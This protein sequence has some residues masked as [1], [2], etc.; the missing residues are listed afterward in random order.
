MLQFYTCIWCSVQIHCYGKVHYC[1][2]TAPSDNIIIV[3]YESNLIIICLILGVYFLH[4]FIDLC[5]VNKTDNLKLCMFLYF[6]YSSLIEMIISG[7]N[8]K[9]N[10]AQ[11][12]FTFQCPSD[13]QLHALSTQIPL[14]LLLSLGFAIARSINADSSTVAVG[15]TKKISY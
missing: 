8:D 10:P 1:L 5:F 15:K 7:K 9:K 6:F 14:P 3:M 12:R 13:L 4:N 2:C 11:N